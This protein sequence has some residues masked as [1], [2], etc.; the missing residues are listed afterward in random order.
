[1]DPVILDQIEFNPSPGRLFKK[2][3]I[4]KGS[5]HEELVR[6]L[7]KEISSIAQPKAMYTITG[8]DEIHGIPSPGSMRFMKQGWFWAESSWKAGSCASI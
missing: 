6:I 2:L 8:I 3:R 5:K 7:V 4:K 1:M